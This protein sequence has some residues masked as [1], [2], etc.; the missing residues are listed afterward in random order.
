MFR[1]EKHKSFKRVFN[2]SSILQKEIALA[3]RY[4]PKIFKDII[5][6]DSEKIIYISQGV[7]DIL[8]DSIGGV[9]KNSQ[10][11]E[12]LKK[13]VTE[14]RDFIKKYGLAAF[15][16]PSYPIVN[17]QYKVRVIA[18]DEKSRNFAGSE[19]YKKRY[20][21]ID[22]VFHELGHLLVKN[23]VVFNSD[24]MKDR[25]LAECAAQAYAVLRHMQLFGNN[26][27]FTKNNNYS[28]VIVFGTT[29]IHHLDVIN[30]KIE[31]LA[32]T[33]GVDLNDLTYEETI[34]FAGEIALKYHFEEAFLNKITEAYQPVIYDCE[35][36][37]RWGS[38]TLK[39]VFEV[40]M[41]TN[42]EDVYRVG[43][44]SL[45]RLNVKEYIDKKVAGND[46]YW[47]EARKQ[48]VEFEQV[49]GI[50]LNLTKARDIELIERGEEPITAII[51]NRAALGTAKVNNLAI[52]P[53]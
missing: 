18:F 48:M 10:K 3:S 47:V 30:Q 21:C 5:L 31:N 25:H 24:S 41:S 20:T 6:C 34:E 26:T 53:V 49:S 13:V 15:V 1:K 22:N 14:C 33:E 4:A 35:E 44:R 37:G 27:E 40:M 39:K 29:P 2:A 16:D 28:R 17:K 11:K 46:P 7:L 23:G 51:K 43:K 32:K 50:E 8:K 12:E 9:L 42:D 45:E 19:N 52:R 38:N 36:K